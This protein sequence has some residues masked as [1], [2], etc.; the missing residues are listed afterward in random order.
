MKQ[1]ESLASKVAISCDWYDAS[2]QNADW[3]HILGEISDVLGCKSRE[4]EGK[5]GYQ[6][7]FQLFDIEQGNHN[8]R[9]QIF[10][11][12]PDP[13]KPGKY[14]DRVYVTANGKSGGEVRDYLVGSLIE[15]NVKRYDSAVDLMI[16]DRTF[17]RRAMQIAKLC[18]GLK[19]HYHP[20]GTKTNGRTYLYNSRVKTALTSKNQ[21]L[22]EAQIA[23]YE[24]GKQLAMKPNDQGEAWAR[25]EMRWRPGKPETQLAAQAVEPADVWGAFQ[26]TVDALFIGSGGQGAVDRID[27]PR[28]QKSLP[29]VAEEMRKIRAMKTLQHMFSQYSRSYDTLV[30]ILGKEQAQQII[31]NGFE[32][33]QPETQ[34]AGELYEALYHPATQH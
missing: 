5:R 30:E 11:E 22:P 2:V 9:C 27:L 18:D 24:K 23:F 29:E 31:L 14:L 33:V 3:V 32:R 1:A 8:N 13:N 28:F 15:H 20:Q 21:R 19:K 10:A 7:G 6:R 34:S 4:I 12:F 16:T 26:W 17:A 25:L